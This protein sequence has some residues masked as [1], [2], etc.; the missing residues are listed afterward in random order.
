MAWAA[1]GEV[2][3]TSAKGRRGEHRA[4]ALLEAAGF[5]VCRS[6]A[7]KGPADLVAWD[8]M[9]IRFISVKSGGRY[10]SAAEREQLATMP[11]PA[12]SSIEVWR[13]VP[14]RLV[15]LIEWLS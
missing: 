10:A 1:W 9:T 14:R 12:N 11:R 13:F 4:R 3:N 8:A 5:S 15:P 6:A 7:S 2:L